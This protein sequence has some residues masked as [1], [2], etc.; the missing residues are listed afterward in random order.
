MGRL[1]LDDHV[2][3]CVCV[4]VIPSVS[5]PH[6]AM[7]HLRPTVKFWPSGGKHTGWMDSVTDAASFSEEN[8]I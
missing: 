5:R 4:C 8:F 3:V 7:K 6:P 2:S 1:E